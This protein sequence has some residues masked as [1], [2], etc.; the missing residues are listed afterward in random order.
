MEHALES[1]ITRRRNEI[2]R[3][4]GETRGSRAPARWGTYLVHGD[5]YADHDDQRERRA[6]DGRASPPT[7]RAPHRGARREVTLSFGATQ[8]T[9]YRVPKP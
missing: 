9:S 5:A 6:L 4:D 7:Q 2:G 8:Q 3:G 1:L